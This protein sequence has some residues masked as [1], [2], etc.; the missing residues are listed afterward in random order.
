MPAW[1]Q[2]RSASSPA[3]AAGE[4]D[5]PL[6]AIIVTGEKA[7]RSLAGTASS[8]RVFGSSELAENPGA[9]NTQELLANTPNVTASGVQNLAPAVRGVDGTGPAQGADAFLGGTR[10][11]LNVTID[12]RTA[13]YNEV[14]FGDL[15]LWDVQ[16]VEVFAGRRVC[17]RGA[18][19]SQAQW[20]T[21]PPD[22]IAGLATAALRRLRRH[23]DADPVGAAGYR[24]HRRARQRPVPV[25]QTTSA[26]SPYRRSR[27]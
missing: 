23:A 9:R 15:G 4:G 2:Q 25:A 7:E 22:R 18:I 10:P 19:R 20:C 26:P 5:T 3:P 27:S 17:S 6:P 1:A 12:G 24:H 13:T 21:R 16:Q 14:I 11:R 8:V